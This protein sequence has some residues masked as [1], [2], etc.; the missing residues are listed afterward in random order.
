MKQK[1]KNDYTLL[2]IG[3][4]VVA[5]ILFVYGGQ[6]GWFKQIYTI[7]NQY[8]ATGVNQD[9]NTFTQNYQ[10]YTNNLYF[11]QNTICVGDT[12]KA[13]V[14]TNIANGQCTIFAKTN[15]V[16]EIYKNVKLNGNGD[17]LESKA[18]LA[19]GVASFRVICCDA[20]NNCRVS[21]DA[22]VTVNVCAQPQPPAVNTCTDTDNGI[23]E[24][25]AG[26]VTA[27]GVDHF[28]NCQ[29]GSVLEYY[30]DGFNML[31]TSLIACDNGCSQSIS[32]GFCETPPVQPVCADTDSNLG[33][34]AYLGVTG[35]C[36][37][38]AGIKTDTC[39][40]GAMLKEYYCEGSP[41]TCGYT[42]Y[43]CP[44]NI[45]GSVCSNGKCIIPEP[46][47][48]A[49]NCDNYNVLGVNFNTGGCFVY[50]TQGTSNEATICLNNNGVYVGLTGSNCDT[51]SPLT[52][53]ICCCR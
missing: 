8:G 27:N 39:V 17:Y 2:F 13:I 1:K 34:T 41:Q 52:P 53:E 12:A 21:N 4:G 42:T 38:S 10:Q 37:D 26:K 15:N 47:T 44:A 18:I 30:C 3:L 20:N 43:N 46:T 35:T 28:D 29:G 50:N 36:T 31:R 7:T 33:Y 5:V 49:Q 32:G 25:L 19:V 9:A 51:S 14:D 40:D 48:C 24:Y 16:W 22:S 6:Q 11:E 45:V 23:K